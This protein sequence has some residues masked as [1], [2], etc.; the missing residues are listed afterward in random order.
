SE[1]II[2]PMFSQ[3]IR[4]WRDMPLKIFQNVS[5]FRC[6]TNDTRPLIRNR[7]TIGFIEGHAAL[8]SKKAAMEH[9]EILW[10]IY[11]D[12]FNELGIP[13]KMVEVPNWD[14]FAGSK[15]T[16][17]GYVIL[18][19]G[20]S[21]E[22]FTSAYLGTTFS[23]IFDITYL[24]KE[25]KN[26]NAH[27]LCYGPSIDRILASIISQYSDNSGLILLSNIAPIDIII[28]PIFNK[29]NQNQIFNYCELIQTTLR[30]NRFRVEIDTNLE[31]T[32]GS[33]FYQAE[34]FGYPVRIEIGN[35]ELIH[36]S[37]TVCRRDTLAK[38][39][40]NFNHEL[41]EILTALLLDINFSMKRKVTDDFKKHIIDLTGTT[42]NSY[43]AKNEL[44]FDNMYLIGWCGLKKCAEKIETKTNFSLIGF[45][46][47]FRRNKLPCEICNK[48][49]KVSILCKRY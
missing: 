3:W 27:L 44:R 36:Q 49:G 4:S 30:N 34:R 38:Y 9:L 12:L 37:V 14:R 10:S 46:R 5:I 15:L 13:L 20:R 43:I 35:K 11:T 19:G 32:P 25:K 23:K 21:M 2:Y 31:S 42:L 18:P 29:N 1:L 7:E 16:I 28:V 8:E 45:D 40:Y 33:K 41:L 17:D 26:V 39:T 24:S 6:E 47:D 22:L 48:E